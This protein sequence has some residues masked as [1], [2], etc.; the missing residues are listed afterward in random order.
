MLRTIKTSLPRN[1]LRLKGRDFIIA[2]CFFIFIVNPLAAQ[3]DTLHVHYHRYDGNYDAWNLWTWDKTTNANAKAIYPLKKYDDYGPIFRLNKKDY[4]KGDAV[5][6]V[7]R[8]GEWQAKDEPDRT[9]TAGLGDDI[10]ILQGERQIFTKPPN[11]EPPILAAYIDEPDEVNIALPVPIRFEPLKP[12]K[13]TITDN[14]GHNLR[15]L[16]VEKANPDSLTTRLAVKT[17][18]KFTLD[19]PVH[20]YKVEVSGFKPRALSF[21]GL[22]DGADYVSDADLGWFY[23]PEQTIFRLFAPTAT[24]VTLMLYD[25]AVKGIGQAV[26]LAK[27]EHG[28]WETTVS[29]DQ[30]NKYYT[31][32]LSGNDPHFNPNKEVIDPY[33]RCNTGHTG[34]GFI[35]VDQTPV[36]DR[37]AFPPD[38]AIIYE[39]HVRDFSIDRE[40]GLLQ[41][42]KYL[43]L[44][45]TGATLRNEGKVKTG[46]D[47]LLELGINTVQIMPIQDFDNDEA[48]EGYNWGYMPVHFNSPDGWYAG[49]RHNAKRVEEFKKLVDAL[50]KKGLRVI[51]DVVY[52]HTSE[53]NPFVQYNFNGVAPG[54]Y[55]RVNDEGQYWNGSG[56]G[57]EFRSEGPMARKFILDSVKYWVNEYKV[58]GFRFDLMGLMDLETMTEISEELHKIDPNILVY[59][60]PW[61]AGSTP[62]EI[63][64]KG[65]QKGLGFGVFNDNFRNALKSSPF[66]VEKTYLVDG[67]RVDQVKE[68]LRGSINDFALHP[69][70]SINYVECHD[71]RTFW[72]Q[73]YH[74]TQNRPELRLTEED[75]IRMNKLGAAIIFTAQGMP[76]IQ[77]GQEF[78]RTKY[79]VENSYNQPDSI[80]Q[81]EW[82][83]KV[84]YADV[85]AYY[86]GLIQLRQAHP[87]FRLKT[88][89]EVGRH[90]Q[91]LDDDLKLFIPHNCI[92]FQLDD[93]ADSWSKILVLFNPNPYNVLFPL[94][95]GVWTMVADHEKA[96]VAPIK[97]DIEGEIKLTKRSAMILHLQAKKT[98]SD[99]KLGALI[100]LSEPVARH[101]QEL[102]VGFARDIDEKLRLLLTAEYKHRL[103]LNHLLDEQMRRKYDMP[104]EQFMDS[105]AMAAQGHTWDVQRDAIDWEMALNEMRLMERLLSDLRDVEHG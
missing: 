36:A 95:D 21:R 89:E 13:V 24:K 63:T 57:N 39:A 74:I 52:N 58:D 7:P 5:G 86:Q 41:R 45:E 28:V 9:W 55:Y 42:G 51:M 76:F 104:F 79:D 75:Y 26:A 35:F 87:A 100:Q 83:R 37:P 31:Y 59:G 19:L 32:K 103:S 40:S 67:V 90:L 8:K 68:G 61:A 34:R 73:L 85:V 94:P 99:K 97:V 50:H 82:A 88:R 16:E 66:S 17:T 30:L 70:E 14:L 102:E 3:E 72:D 29:G 64:T 11:I 81:I 27:K 98:P 65:A 4:G 77:M 78:L 10:W 84:K 38:E 33:S 49:E 101:L 62:I 25:Q 60:E 54:Y 6:I 20:L 71:N 44:T 96:G 69:H 91:F 18:A 23:T 56:C 22:L 93:P 80:N 12:P 105:R 2:L 92:G 48:G 53:T 1:A 43:G 47:H 46:L 15:V